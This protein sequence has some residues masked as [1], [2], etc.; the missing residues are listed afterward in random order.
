V[1]QDGLDVRRAKPSDA[2]AIAAF[3]NRALRRADAVDRQRVI[4]RFA[5]VGL[6][7]AERDNQLVGLLG[8]QAENLVARVSDLLIY[9][10]QERQAARA[11]LLTMEQNA[12]ELQC[13]T[14]LLLLP[15]PRPV[16]LVEFCRGVGYEPRAY[17]ELPK[18]WQEAARDAGLKNESVLLK[19]LKTDRVIRPL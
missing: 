11:L 14:I 3:V 19:K 16:V 17:A 13:E 10:S 2:D 15:T 9:P 12:R 6:L 1:E 5:S 8:W 18:V 7:V 4:E